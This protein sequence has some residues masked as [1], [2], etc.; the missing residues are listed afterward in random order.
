MPVARFSRLLAS[1]KRN[2]L[3]ESPT[4]R[5]PEHAYGDGEFILANEDH[6]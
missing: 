5:K 6:R 1:G 4:G 2:E 3:D